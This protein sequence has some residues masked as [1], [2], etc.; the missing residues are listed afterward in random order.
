MKRKIVAGGSRLGRQDVWWFRFCVVG[1]VL[2]LL[3]ARLFHS[4]TFIQWGSPVLIGILV[5]TSI[6]SIVRNVRRS[7]RDRDRVEITPR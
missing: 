7:F 5:V 2:L 3:S 6:P 1:V 4:V